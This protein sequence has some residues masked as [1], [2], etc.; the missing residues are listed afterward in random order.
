M[1]KTLNH[2]FCDAVLQGIASTAT[3]DT[4]L[5]LITNRAINAINAIKNIFSVSIFHRTNLRWLNVAIEALAFS[6]RPK[7]FFCERECQSS[8]CRIISVGPKE[9]V[10]RAFP[11]ANAAIC[12]SERPIR[13]ATA[14]LGGPLLETAESN[15]FFGSADAPTKRKVMVP[16][17]R[18]VSGEPNYCHAAVLLARVFSQCGFTNHSPISVT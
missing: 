3:R 4:V 16:I 1:I 11:I 8:F 9:S 17:L 10:K 2:F 7:I 5:F 14:G 18:V 15:F 13:T 12:I 6:N